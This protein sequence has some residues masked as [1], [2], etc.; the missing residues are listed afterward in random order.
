MEL[1]I[2]G[3]YQGK[4]E[5]AREKYGLSEADIVLCREDEEA[6][7]GARCVGRLEEF[8][9]WCVD[10]GTDPVGYFEERKETWQNSVLLCADIFC[11]VVPMEARLRKWRE[12][13]GRLTAYLA[14]QAKSVTRLFCGI[15]TRLK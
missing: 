5:Y 8:V 13:T 15:P 11:G 9:L 3:A 2:G 12:E 7:L 14:G 1:V 10:H 6:V 4:L